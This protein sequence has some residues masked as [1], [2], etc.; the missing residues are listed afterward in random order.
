M[1]TLDQLL[2]ATSRTFALGIERL[3]Q[4]LQEEIKV[5]YLVLRISDYLEDNESMEPARKIELLHRWHAVLQGA[6]P[7]STLE[8]DLIA[9]AGADDS[10]PD[11]QAA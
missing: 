10:I 2:R 5:A 3:P 8:P 7:V 11:A 4:P 1:P 9:A 6:D